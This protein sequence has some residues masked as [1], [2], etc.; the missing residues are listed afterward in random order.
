MRSDEDCEYR[1]GIT[2]RSSKGN[3]GKPG[4]FVDCGLQQDVFVPLVLEQNVRVTVQ[5][6]TH[7][8][9]ASKQVVACNV[10]SPDLPREAAGYYW[11]YN[12]RQASSLSN[13]F[14]ECPYDGGYDASIGT[15]ERGLPVSSL[16]DR[17][18][19]R[20]L[21]PNW[22]HLLVVFG[23]VAG[24]EVALA[25][26]QELRLAGVH[27]AAEVFDFWINL[28]PGQGSRTIR[29]EEAVWVGLACLSP[30]MEARNANT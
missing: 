20:S 29:T 8:Q 23:G 6:P 22:Q 11:G 21:Q 5:L 2:T 17:T 12:I 24:L 18:S 14:T 16:A 25:N 27:D 10:V 1:E 26:D 3:D 13:V 19:D 9:R 4:V 28:V 7:P 15:S 30:F